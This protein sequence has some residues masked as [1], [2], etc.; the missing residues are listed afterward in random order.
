[1]AIVTRTNVIVSITKRNITTM[2][3]VI[4]ATKN[5]DTVTVATVKNATIIIIIQAAEVITNVMIEVI[6]NG[7]TIVT[8]E[9]ATT[10]MAIE[11]IATAQMLAQL[12]GIL[13]TTTEVATATNTKITT[14]V[15]KSLRNL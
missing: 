9:T 12:T 1:M 10:A 11:T 5:V 15:H 7:T 3:I 6:V 8:K 2:A 13:A 4:E 14:T